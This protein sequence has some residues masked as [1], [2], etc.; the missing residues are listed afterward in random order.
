MNTS[1]RNAAAALLMIA[2]G[3]GLAACGE[4]VDVAPAASV[5][6]EIKPQEHQGHKGL[7]ETRENDDLPVKPFEH[8]L[9]LRRSP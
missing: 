7:A 9:R 1:I 5:R 3:S 4:V 6:E 8:Q 2:A